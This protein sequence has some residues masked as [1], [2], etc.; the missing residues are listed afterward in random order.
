M[1]FQGIGVES[2]RGSSGRGVSAVPGLDELDGDPDALGLAEALG[3]VDFDGLAE[4]LGEVDFD[5]LAEALGEVH[6]GLP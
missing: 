2:V 5:G 4:A 6:G 1:V 3:E